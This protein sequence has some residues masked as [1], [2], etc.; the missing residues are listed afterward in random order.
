VI[1]LTYTPPLQR[2]LQAPWKK[3][4]SG[5]FSWG[6]ELDYSIH[7]WRA[8]LPG[9]YRRPATPIVS[10]STAMEQHYLD[11]VFEDY[12]TQIRFHDQ[13]GWRVA[14]RLAR[15]LRRHNGRGWILRCNLPLI[16]IDLA[17]QHEIAILDGYSIVEMR[18][19]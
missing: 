10:A 13:D 7:L 19:A 9:D 5:Q 18:A 6:D 3:G 15:V 17:Q 11:C 2:D 8:H 4:V 14:Y 16:Q 12:E 1:Y